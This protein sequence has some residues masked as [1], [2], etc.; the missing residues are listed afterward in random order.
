MSQPGR[1][2]WLHQAQPK[3]R[4]YYEQALDGFSTHD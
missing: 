2:L 4:Q 1:E 3:I